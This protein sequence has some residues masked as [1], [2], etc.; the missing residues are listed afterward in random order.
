M[1]PQ[2]DGMP[3]FNEIGLVDLGGPIESFI[4]VGVIVSFVFV[5]FLFDCL[6]GLEFLNETVDDILFVLFQCRIWKMVTAC[7]GY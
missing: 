6:L 2:V 4:R 7:V 5:I 1:N 3:T